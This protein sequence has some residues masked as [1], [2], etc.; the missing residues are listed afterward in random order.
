MNRHE[1]RKAAALNKGKPN[2]VDLEA[3]AF[4]EDMDAI[5]DPI[6]FKVARQKEK[7]RTFARMYGASGK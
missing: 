2:Y 6:A 1:R 3:K 5:I 7:I 4:N